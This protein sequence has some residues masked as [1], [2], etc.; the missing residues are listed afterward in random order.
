[1]MTNNSVRDLAVKI[2]DEAGAA[3]GID[4]VRRLAE[5]GWPD[6]CPLELHG[7]DE[8]AVRAAIKARRPDLP[9]GLSVGHASEPF[10]VSVQ[11]AEDAEI[12]TKTSTKG[13]VAF[14]SW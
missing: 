12:A 6:S 4:E 5:R 11:L 2:V 9:V 14:G 13:S 3:G 10:E 1:M 8:Q 7:L